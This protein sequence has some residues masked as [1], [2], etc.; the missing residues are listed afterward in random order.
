MILS[1]KQFSYRF[2]I[3]QAIFTAR[4]VSRLASRGEQ[5]LH[6]FYIINSSQARLE[7]KSEI[8]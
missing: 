4:R 8:L 7:K 5:W 6:V 3:L 2:E 1:D